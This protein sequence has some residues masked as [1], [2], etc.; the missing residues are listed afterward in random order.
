VNS[1][2]LT[3]RLAALLTIGFGLL[4]YTDRLA[5][6]ETRSVTVTGQGEAFGTPDQAMVS[7]GVQTF[8]DTVI[9]A[10]RENQSV[11]EK[12]FAALEEQGIA[13]DDIQT[14]N[15]SIW[16]EQDHKEP[17]RGQIA[18]YRVSNVVTVT[19]DDIEQ[20]GE[21]LAAV[22]NAGANTIHGIHF[23]VKDTAALEEKAQKAAMEDARARAEALANLAGVQ[24]GEVLTISSSPG[25]GYPEPMMARR[26]M[27]MADAAP[28]PGIAPGQQSLT[29]LIEASF[30]I[31]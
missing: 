10:T 31:R 8:A 19:I 5:L 1:I 23:A 15:Y 17:H 11:I 12:I 3:S 28:A 16:A 30:A 21:V 24:L 26:S 13:E 7:A 22:T 6:G 4:G 29:V 27:E 18:G 20:V 2:Q 9:A 25:P 14:T